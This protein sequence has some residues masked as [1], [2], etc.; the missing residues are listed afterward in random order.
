M[1][2]RA[3]L[4]NDLESARRDF[5]SLLNC[6]SADE[7]RKPTTGTRWTNEELL[8]H[9]VFGYLVVQ[10]LLVL[11]KLFGKLPD[12]VSRG[13]AWLLNATTPVFHHV[14]YV[15]SRFASRVFNRKRM[16]A[17]M[18]RVIDSLQRSLAKETDA[19][20]DRGMHFPTRWDPYFRDY[21]TLAQVYAYPG[22]HYAHHRRQLTLVK[23]PPESA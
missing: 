20:L 19:A 18:D 5:H 4:S 3:V 16:G 8:F 17:K 6:V 9:M 7:W 1:T 11:V 14:N 15:G 21:M 10:R 12:P 23:I 22:Q 13:Y 2:D